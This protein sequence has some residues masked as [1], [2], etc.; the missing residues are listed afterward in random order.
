MK[1]KI[2]PQHLLA[3]IDDMPNMI[4]YWDRNLRC[5]Y[6]NNIYSHWFDKQSSDII[7]M[8]FQELAGEHLFSLNEPH[9]VKALAGE[10]QRFEREL[11]KPNGSMGHIIGHYLPDFNDDGTV[12]GFSILASEITDLKCHKKQLELVI[13]STGVGIWDWQVQTGETVFNERWA[14][15]IGYTLEELSPVTINTWIKYAHPDDLKES[16]HLLK[17]HWA[18]KTEY[19]LFESRMKH[20]NGSWVWVFDTGQVVEWESDGVPKRMIGT[21]LD[22]TERVES[23]IKLDEANKKLEE[24]SYLDSLTEIPNRRA[25]QERLALE[26]SVAKRTKTPISLLVIDLDYFKEYNDNYGHESGDVALFTVAKLI[27]KTLSRTTDFVAR[28]GGEEIVVILPYTSIEGATFTAKK[29]L[30]SVTDKNIEHS[31][32]KFKKI[33]TV[34]IGVA[35]AEAKFDE[36]FFHADN[37]MYLAKKNGRNRYE[38]HTEK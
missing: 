2:L 14:N 33:L 36:I 11:T 19:Y 31:G 22:I 18:G 12:R 1:K 4:G 9:I 26:V 37:A 7:G 5:C 15:I 24:L 28:Y 6:A 27:E 21:H 29:I 13:K 30:Q 32:S 38:I 17:E 34:S 10:P 20:K 35:S 8:T 23:T 16:E 25:Y 3:I